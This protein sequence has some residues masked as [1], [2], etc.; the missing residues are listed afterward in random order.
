MTSRPQATAYLEAP[1]KVVIYS[2]N[3]KDYQDICLAST[4][5]LIARRERET[6]IYGAK[7]PWQWVYGT[8]VFED[9]KGES[10]KVGNTQMSESSKNPI[11]FRQDKD[12]YWVWRVRNIPYPAQFYQISVDEEKNQIVIRTTNHKYFKR[13]DAPGNEKFWNSNL[14]WEWNFNALTVSHIKPAR[15]RSADEADMQWRKSL[16]VVENNQPSCNPQ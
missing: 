12:G 1:Y 6:R 2:D 15:V 5:E 13:I 10:R 8:D 16:P 7:T 9:S 4:G 11:F 3:G 14:K